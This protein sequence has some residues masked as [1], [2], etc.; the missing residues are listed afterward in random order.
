MLE[1]LNALF[2]V[3]GLKRCLAHSRHSI[4]AA[5]IIAR[6]HSARHPSPKVEWKRTSCQCGN[7]LILFL[8]K[9][10]DVNQDCGQGWPAEYV[11]FG[12]VSV[13]SELI[14]NT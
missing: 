4:M 11:L 3:T 13:L 1:V 9:A 14:A 12:L 7:H 2:Y 5:I 10:S 6:L 8:F